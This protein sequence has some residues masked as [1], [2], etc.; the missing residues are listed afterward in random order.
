[1]SDYNAEVAERIMGWNVDRSLRQYWDPKNPQ[2]FWDKVP[3]FV[4]VGWCQARL[5]ETLQEHGFE[6]TITSTPA[7][8]REL[9]GKTFTAF[10]SRQN[11]THHAT[12]TDENLAVCAAALK[13]YGLTIDGD[14]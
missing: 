3:D 9:R 13:A 12:R 2:E 7:D 8:F 4:V 11:A 5:R 6:L 14:E 10:V 1:M